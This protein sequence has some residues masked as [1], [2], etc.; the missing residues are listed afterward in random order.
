[1]TG[2]FN[3]PNTVLDVNT[4]NTDQHFSAIGERSVIGTTVQGEDIW[5]GTA[6]SI[7]VPPEAGEQMTIVSSSTA[8]NGAT[9]TGVL[10]VRIEY[11]D[12]SGLEQTEDI[13][14]NGTTP[15]NTVAT[16]IAFVNDF[17]ALTVGSNGVAKGTLYIYKL[18]SATTI[19]NLITPGGNKSL[20]INRKIPTG[21]DFYITTWTISESK[22]KES[23]YRL[24][25][26]CAPHGASLVEGFLFKRTAKINGNTISETMNPPIKICSGAIVK[27]S[28]WA[29]GGGGS[30][31]SSYNG[32]LQS[33]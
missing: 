3:K 10:T 9:T 31:S 11:L 4:F 21:K 2:V 13:T 20:V 19:Y 25:A 8:D 29:T 26:T 32:Y 27:V 23:S 6:V 15:V 33:N 12:G 16:D 7:P 22:N 5:E 1:M 17:Y 24:R 18:G 14:V 28:A 30:G